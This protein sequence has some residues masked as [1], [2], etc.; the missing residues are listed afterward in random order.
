ME[1]TRRDVLGSILILLGALMVLGA[2]GT[3]DVK[4]FAPN[5]GF[6][7]DTTLFVLG[8]V[9]FLVTIAGVRVLTK[10]GGDTHGRRRA[11]KIW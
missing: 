11:K 5:S 4:S 1:W 3:G 6:A 7:S 10:K 2:V 8:I 9:G